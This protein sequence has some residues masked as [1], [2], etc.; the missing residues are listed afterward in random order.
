MVSYFSTTK[1]N[2][3]ME[4]E[5]LN[6]KE[7]ALFLCVSLSKLFKMCMRKELKY[8]KVGRISLFKKKDLE[9]YLQNHAY[10]TIQDLKHIADKTL[11]S[12]KIV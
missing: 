10:L 11:A 7:A 1:T 9:D 12:S 4:K 5:N 8:Y 6:T 3:R 2:L